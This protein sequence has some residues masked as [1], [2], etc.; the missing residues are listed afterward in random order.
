MVFDPLNLCENT[1]SHFRGDGNAVSQDSRFLDIPNQTVF[2]AILF[3]ARIPFE[4]Q[5]I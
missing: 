1:S 5:D 2:A 4:I 3:Q